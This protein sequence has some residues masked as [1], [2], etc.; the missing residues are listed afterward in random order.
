MLFLIIIHLSR[1]KD[2]KKCS[3]MQ[4]SKQ[5]IKKKVF[6]SRKSCIYK[7]KVVPLHVNFGFALFL[8]E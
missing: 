5:E 1:C 8:N 4:I 3:Y 6:F 2:T 7:K